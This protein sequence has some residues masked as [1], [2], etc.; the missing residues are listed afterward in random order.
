MNLHKARIAERSKMQRGGALQ[1]LEYLK[2]A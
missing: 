1:G 2:A